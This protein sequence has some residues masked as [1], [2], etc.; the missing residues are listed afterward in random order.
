MHRQTTDLDHRQRKR[1]KIKRNNLNMLWF[2]CSLFS[3]KHSAY[4][5]ITWL[6]FVVHARHDDLRPL[7]K[8]NVQFASIR[9]RGND[10]FCFSFCFFR[11][12]I[13]REAIWMSESERYDSERLYELIMGTSF[14]RDA[15]PSDTF[16]ADVDGG[17]RGEHRSNFP[18]SRVINLCAL[19]V[20]KKRSWHANINSVNCKHEQLKHAW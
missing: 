11:E 13:S 7:R 14:L 19:K 16:L 6:A 10:T 8:H 5:S 18:F 9:D 1:W 4:G 17:V 3:C 12:S 2:A 20:S 15:L